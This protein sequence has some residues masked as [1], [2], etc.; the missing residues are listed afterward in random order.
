LPGREIVECAQCERVLAGRTAGRIDLPLA[1]ASCALLLM[2]PAAMAPMMSVSTL[3]ALRE[4]WLYTGVRTLTQQGFPPLAMLVL[5]TSIVLPFVYLGGLVWVL[6]NLHFARETA[7][8]N[9]LLGRM[10]RWVLALRPWMMIEVFLIGGFVAYTRMDTVAT[11]EVDLGGWCLITATFALLLALTQLDDRTVWAALEPDAEAKEASAQAAQNRVA[12][13]VTS[14][15]HISCITCDFIV[16]VAAEGT[17]CPRCQAR[18]HQRKP[19][20][21]RRTTALLIAGYLLYIPANLLPMLTLVQLGREDDNTILSG[22]FELVRN[23]LW[24]LAVIVFVASIVLPLLKLSSLTWMLLAIRFRSARLLLTRTRLYRTIDL[25][26]R[27]SNIDVFMGSVIVALLQFGALT[28]VRVGNGMVAF[29]AVVAVTMFATL[30][31]DARLMWDA[32]RRPS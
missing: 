29:A 31:F 22:V 21:L 28:S 32:A 12:P 7:H 1:L 11:V 15:T 17:P 2:I 30:E 4:S 23:D 20:A 26:G 8:E 3:G 5:I 6:L 27:W 24:P 16:P 19:H 14:R 18:L 13:P 10:Y 9:R 25:I